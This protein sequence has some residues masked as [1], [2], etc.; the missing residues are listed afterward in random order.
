MNLVSIWLTLHYLLNHM[1]YTTNESAGSGEPYGTNQ[2]IVQYSM[3]SRPFSKATQ[4]HKY[5][6]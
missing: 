2:D 5:V 3:K 4:A 6:L 1:I